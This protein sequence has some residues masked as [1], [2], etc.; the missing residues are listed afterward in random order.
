[1]VN[2]VLIWTVKRLCRMIDNSIANDFDFNLAITG[3]RGLGKS[4]LAIK[5]A[6]GITFGK[7]SMNKDLLYTK[8]DIVKALSTRKKKVIVGD[9][10]VQTAFNRDFY[11]EYNKTLIKTLTMYRDSCN[12]FISCIPNF[13][14]LDNQFRSLTKMRIDVVKRGIGIIHVPIK[15]QYT[16]DIW[17]V[18][19]NEKVEKEWLS[20]G[21]L[22]KPKYT[23]LSTFLGIVK[24]GDLPPATRKQYLRIKTKKRNSIYEQMVAEQEQ[25]MPQQTVDANGEDLPMVK[26]EKMLIGMQIKNQSH[27]DEMCKLLNL[28]PSST[29]YKLRKNLRDKFLNTTISSY[30]FDKN[31][32]AVNDKAKK[33]SQLQTTMSKNSITQ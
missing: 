26:L 33:L 20:K 9:E 22:A 4:T 31:S 14:M 25:Q 15:S 27:F 5:L 8:E 29:I 19:N 11:S 28:K 17:D 12:L 10:I 30:Y 7:F 32:D 13:S 24:F 1:M 16:R 3:R 23:K 6:K 18:A 2:V 21:M